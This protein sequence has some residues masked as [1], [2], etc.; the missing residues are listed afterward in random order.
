MIDAGIKVVL[1]TDDMGYKLARFS[2]LKR[3]MNFSERHILELSSKF[4]SGM[5]D[6]SFIL[7]EI[8]P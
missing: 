7:V 3:L 1:V 5:L 8:T 4:M 2:N 6:L